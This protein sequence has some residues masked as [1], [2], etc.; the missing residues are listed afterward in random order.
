MTA[1]VAA[2]AA[3]GIPQLVDQGIAWLAALFASAVAGAIAAAVTKVTGA[4]LDAKAARPSRRPWNAP[5]GSGWNG[6]WT[7]RPICRSASG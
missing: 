6:C 1:P 4:A 3:E 2:L 7:R 5:R